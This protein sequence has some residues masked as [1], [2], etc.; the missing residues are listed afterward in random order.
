MQ[1]QVGQLTPF[2]L[3]CHCPLFSSVLIDMF[4]PIK[5]K[6]TKSIT[7]SACVL[8]IAYNSTR[9]VHL[10]IAEMQSTNDFIMAWQSS[11]SKRVIHPEH[12]NSD[13]GKTF[14][15]AQAPLKK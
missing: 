1:Q 14:V 5:I 11:I 3:K 12:V 6:K 9:V 8:A 13:Q 2:R 15:G 10:E 4:G 7:T